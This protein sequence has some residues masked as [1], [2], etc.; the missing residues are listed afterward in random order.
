MTGSVLLWCAIAAVGASFG[1]FA[2]IF[3]KAV[4]EGSRNLSLS[5]GENAS[6][7]FEEVFLFIPPARVAELARTGALAAFFAFFIP[8]F[9]FTDIASTLCGVALGSLFAVFA[10]SMPGRIVAG[11]K[12]RRRRKF[13]DQL[14]DALSS[15]SN[16]LRAG[17]SVN[18]AFESVAEN[19]EP[20]ISQEFGVVRQ[21]MRVGMGFEEA[22]ESLERRVGS[23]DLSLVVSAI[24][25]ARRTGGNLTETFDRI[26]ETIRARMRIER[27]VRT[28]TAQGRM[29]GIIVSAMPFVLGLAMTVLKPDLMIPFLTSFNGILCVGGAVALVFC[30]WLVI[31]RIIRIDV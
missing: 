19:G 23:D 5:M 22:L 9:S 11:M 27:R 18:Q 26:S 12:A 2:W 10:F 4:S 6:R 28:L 25:I 15:M 16:A 17:F 7:G 8:L 3:A 13:N 21:Q 31:R 24:E 14:V 20:P 1:G 30:G 29:Q